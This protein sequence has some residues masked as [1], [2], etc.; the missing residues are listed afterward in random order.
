MTT[1]FTK[2]DW[3]HGYHTLDVSDWPAVCNSFDD[4]TEE[5]VT[6]FAHFERY[7]RDCID[8]QH[9]CYFAGTFVLRGV[10]ITGPEAET[11]TYHTLEDA[12]VVFG[13]DAVMEMEK[14]MEKM[15]ND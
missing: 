6:V 11:T 9:G 12:V 14:H 7:P 13:D 10:E 2:P 3:A 15:N 5:G 1:T 8:W 4:P